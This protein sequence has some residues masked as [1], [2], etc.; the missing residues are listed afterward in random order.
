MTASQFIIEPLD[1]AKHRREAF[2]C[3]VAALN[4]FLRT[5]ARREMEADISASF[6]LV[7]KEKQEQIAGF[8]TLSSASI[9]RTELP[10]ALLKKLPRYNQMPAT[11]L[12]RLAR[13]LDFK[14]QGIG[15]RL[16]MS[17]LSRAVHGSKQVAG[18]LVVVTDPKN[19]EARLFY[20][21]FGFRPL[22]DD[23]MF[24]LM[25][26]AAAQLNAR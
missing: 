8:Y 14:G 9:L 16:M 24:V 17:A 7:P 23:R 13:S 1:P 11:L 4:D 2:D 26:D 21:S 6:V 18:S 25:K 15:A 5:R 10:E 20:E 22:N 3:G 12:G 19:E